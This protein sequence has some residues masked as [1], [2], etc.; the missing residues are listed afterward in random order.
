MATI[1]ALTLDLL[2]AV[3]EPTGETVEEITRPGVSG[4]AFLRLG[5]RGRPYALRGT[6]FVATAA[7]ADTF[8]AACLALQGTLVSVVDDAGETHAGQMCLV[9]RPGRLRAVSS[10]LGT[11]VANPTYRVDVEFSMLDPGASA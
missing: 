6:L 10:A 8:R 9:A 5:A 3:Y 1:G 4:H 2:S 11:V 7:D